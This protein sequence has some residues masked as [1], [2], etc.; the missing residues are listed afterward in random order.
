MKKHLYLFISIFFLV[1]F[2]VFTI[3]V[4][5]VDVTYIYNHTYLGFSE[6]NFKFGYKVVEFGKYGSMKTISNVIFYTSLG[7]GVLLGVFGLI[8]LIRNKSFKKV[9]IRYYILLGGFILVAL[10]YLFFELVK[11][12]YSPDSLVGKLKASYPSSHVFIGCSIL[13][14]STY[15]AVKLLNP[16]KK[17]LTYLIYISTGLICVL[18]TFTRLLAL[19]HWLTDI[20]A[21]GLLFTGIYFAFIYFSHRLVKTSE[22]E[23]ETNTGIE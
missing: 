5:T 15:T 12:N 7:Y 19:K 3:L 10:L 13:T 9:N 18:L 21:S 1:S 4:K 20:I 22:T 6:L 16:E 2:I 8:D 14:M 23:K 11:V 17:W